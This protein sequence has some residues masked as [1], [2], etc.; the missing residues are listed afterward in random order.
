[1]E[2]TRR[3]LGLDSGTAILFDD[4]RVGFVYLAIEWFEGVVTV[5]RGLGNPEGLD[6]SPTDEIGLEIE[7]A[8]IKLPWDEI[9]RKYGLERTGH[10]SLNDIF[11][12]EVRPGWRRV[13]ISVGQLSIKLYLSIS[14]VS[15]A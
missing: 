1:M 11:A 9:L 7:I 10:T 15:I 6:P 14:I 12:S 2:D 5:S 3:C 8:P 4:Q 13:A